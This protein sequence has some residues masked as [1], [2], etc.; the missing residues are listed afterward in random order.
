MQDPFGACHTLAK[1]HQLAF[2][3][4]QVRLRLDIRFRAL[5]LL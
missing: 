2:I 5:P 4:C 1:L 3:L